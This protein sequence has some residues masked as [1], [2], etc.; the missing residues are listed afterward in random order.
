MLD[1][2]TSYLDGFL[3]LGIPGFD[4]IVYHKGKEV[5]RH[6]KGFRDVEHTVKVEGN[7]SYN[8]YSAS[9]PIT[10]TAALQLY[11]KGAFKLDDPLYL[12][13]PEFKE[14]YIKDGNKIRKAKKY[15]TIENLFCMTAGL[16]YNVC[17]SNI[18]AAYRET[19]G[20]CPT[21]QTMKYMALD[22]LEF[23]PGDRW[24]YGLC[25]DVLAALVEVVSGTKFSEYVKTN[26]FEPLN[27][28]HSSFASMHY[29][30]MMPQYNMT[31]KDIVRCDNAVQIF[32]L[33]SEYESGGAGCVS[34]VEDYIK[35]C[36][37]LRIGDCILKNETIEMMAK[38]HLNEQCLKTYDWETIK[39][40]G[41]GLGVRCPL[42]DNKRS[43]F[44]WGGM[45]GAFLG[46]DRENEF[47]LFYAQHVLNSPVQNLR[48]HI[49]EIVENV[50]K[51]AELPNLHI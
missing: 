39:N 18:E 21:R 31:T 34:T 5:Y 4:C 11:E 35:F 46:I 14:M 6:T 10:C 20:K 40:Y 37:A 7:E 48:P 25:H 26:I 19:D 29:D 12:Y 51:N 36:E 42:G 45:A 30:N 23:E 8:I 13:M 33:G 38:N 43:D 28:K 27:M 3:K 1:D 16:S 49:V 9:K 24:M 50:I 15:I 22:P 32:K 17:T 2:L 47:S 44:G 41:Y